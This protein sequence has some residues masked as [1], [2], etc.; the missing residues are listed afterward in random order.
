MA[1]RVIAVKLTIDG[2][3]SIEELE[4]VQDALSHIEDGLK[5]L[6]KEMAKGVAE[7]AFRELN[8][9][10]E[11]SALTMS[12]LGFA[13][14]QYKNIAISAGTTSPIGQEALKKA[15][16][17]ER[18]MADVSTAVTNLATR[19]SDLQAALTL[20]QGVFAGFTAFQGVQA[21]LGIENEELVAQLIRG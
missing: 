19:G 17:M 4:S 18:Q 2:K 9:V 3:E 6:D 10:V 1:T 16:E 7:E 14:E 5:D 12:E 13:A 21:S 20:G 8:K 15:G 11:E